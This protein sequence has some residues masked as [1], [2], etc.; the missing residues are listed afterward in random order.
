MNIAQLFILRIRVRLSWSENDSQDEVRGILF[1]TENDR[2]IL[3]N[4]WEL[5]DNNQRETV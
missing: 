2:N 4:N 3:L 5:I 1:R